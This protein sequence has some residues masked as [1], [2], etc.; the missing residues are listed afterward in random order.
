Y[1]APFGDPVIERWT[2]SAS[3]KLERGARVSFANLGVTSASNV[4]YTPLYSDTKSYFTSGTDLVVWNPTTMELVKTLPLPEQYLV[5]GGTGPFSVYSV[6]VLLMREDLVQLAVIYMDADEWGHWGEH[7][8]VVNFDPQTDT[9]VAALQE[10]R[11]E[12]V[13]PHGRK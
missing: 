6:E 8:T 5:Y 1:A 9:F 10:S 13:A 7:M 3:G 12:W 2:V 4:A 11:C